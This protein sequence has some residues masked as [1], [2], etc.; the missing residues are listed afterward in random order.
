[1]SRSKNKVRNGFTLI[2]LMIVVAI[3]GILAAVVYP[4][5]TESIK[6]GKRAE[7]RA[8]LLDIAARQE[9]YYSDNNNQYTSTITDLI[10][11]APGCTV[12]G[13]QSETCLY[14][15]TTTATDSNQKFTAS[16]AP[17]GWVDDACST[18]NIIQTGEKTSAS[19]DLYTCWGK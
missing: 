18:L 12:A 15:L 2:E 10:A 4:S 9:R 11:D 19:G 5:Y 3:V 7:G 8:A 13:V 16:A 6:R 1:M 17:V 14:T